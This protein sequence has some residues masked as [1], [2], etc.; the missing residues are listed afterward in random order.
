MV[1]KRKL[2]TEARQNESDW[3]FILKP[4]IMRTELKLL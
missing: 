4:A 3:K 2:N 1:E